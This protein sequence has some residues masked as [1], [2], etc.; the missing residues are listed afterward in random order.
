[1]PL[2][3]F[4]RTQTGALQSRLNSDVVGA[5]QAVT[6]TLG[7]VV[8]NVIKLAVDAHDHAAT[9]VAAHAPDA[10]RAA[11]VHL[12]GAPHRAAHAAAHPRGHAAERRDEQPH[13]RALQRRRRAARQA[14]RQARRERDEFAHARGAVCATSASRT[15]MYGRDAVRRARPRR[16]GRHRGRL[17][18]R[19]QPRDLR[20]RSRRAPSPRS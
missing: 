9:R 18:R 1:M 15:A 3:F 14:V 11:R 19:R 16:R 4:T 2:A 5:Q 6:T 17:L 20:A 13:R 8:S 12:P 7:T 10:A